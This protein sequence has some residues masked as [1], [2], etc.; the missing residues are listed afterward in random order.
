[1]L[2]SGSSYRG[3][4]KRPDGSAPGA[5]RRRQESGTDVGV[6]RCVSAAA[7]SRQAMTPCPEGAQLS[8]SSVLRP[9]RLSDASIFWAVASCLR[10]QLLRADVARRETELRR[11]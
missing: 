2:R 11:R 3:G 10:M 9:A 4:A 1:M 5:R 6:V 7:L 8:N